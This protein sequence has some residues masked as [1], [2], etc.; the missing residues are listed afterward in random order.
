MLEGYKSEGLLHKEYAK[1]M[2]CCYTRLDG[3]IANYVCPYRT[4]MLDGGRHN[5]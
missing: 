2:T 3:L 5:R 4:K 1:S